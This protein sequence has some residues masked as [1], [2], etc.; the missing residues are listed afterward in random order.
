MKNEKSPKLVIDDIS[1]IN[2]HHYYDS[3]FP[4][5][6][7]IQL[8]SGRISIGLTNG[9]ILFFSANNFDEPYLYFKVDEFP[10]YSLL[11]I[12]DDQII[13]SSGNNLYI[14]YDNKKNGIYDK[15]EKIENENLHGNINKIL[16]MYDK[17]LL[18][19]DNKYISLFNRDK[20]KLILMKHLKV[21]A[22]IMNLYLIQST[23]LLAIVPS[24]QKVLFCDPEK[25]VKTYEIQNVKFYEGIKYDNIICR[26]SKDLL[27]IGGCMGF[28]YLVNLKHKQLIANASL[29][30]KNEIVTCM[31]LIKNGDLVCGT[32]LIV[33]ESESQQEYVSSNLVQYRYENQIFK[34]IH[35]K[36]NIHEDII[37]KLFEIVNHKGIN[38]FATISI[39]GYFKIWD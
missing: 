29:R 33:K 4:V 34:E 38:E 3:K 30:Y 8:D 28:V 25:L 36:K 7:I 1:A 6:S 26:I 35:R 5:C 9:T 18:I 24:L 32:S 17:S 23:L 11:Q 13:C 27:V 21:N 12:E 14:I 19:A 16:L 37:Q 39:D 2:I 10:I 31:Y 20:E 22:S 15:K